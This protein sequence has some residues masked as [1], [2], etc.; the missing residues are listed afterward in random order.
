MEQKWKEVEGLWTGLKDGHEHEKRVDGLL[1][2]YGSGQV[3]GWW[4]VVWRGPG[5][6]HSSVNG[7]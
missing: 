4:T 7:N 5:V 1:D 2:I 3:E 6:G